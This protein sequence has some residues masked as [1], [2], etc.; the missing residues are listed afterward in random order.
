M[1]QVRILVVAVMVAISVG[2]TFVTPHVQHAV[3]KTQITPATTCPSYASDGRVEVSYP[4]NRFQFRP[5]RPGSTKLFIT[6]APSFVVGKSTV[7][8]AGNAYSSLAWASARGLWNGAIICS[9]GSADQWF[10]G[11][12]GSVT[13]KAVLNIVN[14]GF[15]DATVEITVYGAKRAPS[16]ANVL[17]KANSYKNL[18]L[19][20]LAPGDPATVVHV[21]TRSGRVTS[22]VFDQQRKGLASLG[23]DFV[24]PVTA[25]ATSLVLPAITNVGG[26]GSKVT[27]VLRLLAPGLVDAALKITVHS[28]E[29]DFTPLG[30]EDRIIAHQKVI[31]I[32]LTSLVE[33]KPFSIELKAD[34]PI[35][36]SLQTS[37]TGSGASDF[38]WSTPSLPLQHLSMT[39]GG[40]VPT[41]VFTGEQVNVHVDWKGSGSKGGTAEVIGSQIASWQPPSG[42]Q[43]ITLTSK[44]TVTY[45]GAIFFAP[46]GPN[47][48]VS[49]LPL[50]PGATE[51]TST[52]P[53]PDIRVIA[54]D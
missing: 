46:N 48:G 42:V 12:S 8:I 40:H 50:V 38:A 21:F 4:P 32:P 15:S 2:L 14:G 44:G 22:Y 43:S 24:N 6:S 39:V 9:S 13:S 54:R 16:V 45:G 20:G 33:K 1:K 11:G 25:P 17:I 28:D 51:E 3:R 10:A 47:F 34:Q 30:F 53:I 41:F 29:G 31:D 37:I 36:A 7:L 18:S 23:M 35:I 49:Y 27:Q 19:D 52:I 5:V 26:S